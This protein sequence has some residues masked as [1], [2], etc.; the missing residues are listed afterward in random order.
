MGATIWTAGEAR[1]AGWFVPISVTFPTRMSLGQMQRS[2]D[3]SYG[4][5]EPRSRHR[6]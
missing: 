4:E 6:S 1:K 2:R 3:A 5:V